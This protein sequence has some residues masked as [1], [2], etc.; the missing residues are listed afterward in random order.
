MN[1]KPCVN[2]GLLSDSAYDNVAIIR[3]RHTMVE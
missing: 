3:T 1:R 2:S